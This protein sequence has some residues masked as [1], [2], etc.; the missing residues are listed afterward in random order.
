MGDP[1][2]P[3][4][5]LLLVA[6]SVGDLDGGA[7]GDRSASIEDNRLIRLG[8]LGATEPGHPGVGGQLERLT[9]V[10]DWTEGRG[11]VVFR[12]EGGLQG[13]RRLLERLTEVADC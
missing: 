6:E 9:Q 7:A 5:H 11:G 8:G 1:L 13:V 4:L 10:A 2:P 3:S 12:R